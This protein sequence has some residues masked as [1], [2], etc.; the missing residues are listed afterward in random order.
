M[1][2]Q[3][4]RTGQRGLHHLEDQPVGTYGQYRAAAS[5]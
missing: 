4:Q 1:T 3:A 2:D 5:D